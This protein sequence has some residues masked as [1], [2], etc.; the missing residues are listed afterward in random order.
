MAGNVAA[1]HGARDVRGV[2]QAANRSVSRLPGLHGGFACYQF[3]R[4]TGHAWLPHASHH[5]GTGNAGPD[6]TAGVKRIGLDK[7]PRGEVEG[8]LAADQGT[9]PGDLVNGIAVF[10]NVHHGLHLIVDGLA[11]PARGVSR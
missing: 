3:V 11:A 7:L 6:R 9:V 8:L 10:V 2:V 1:D 4:D 5:A